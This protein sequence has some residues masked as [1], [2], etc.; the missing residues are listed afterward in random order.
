VKNHLAH[1]QTLTDRTIRRLAKR[2]E[3][4]TIAELLVV[5]TADQF[6]RPP[7][8]QEIS[9]NVLTLQNRAAELQVQ[10]CAPVPILLGRH[11]IEMGMKPGPDFGVILDAA[12]DA[13]LEGQF[14]DFPQALRWLAGEEGLPVP[15]AV[16]ATL[17]SG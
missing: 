9:E 5:I 17:P 16:R 11:L 10:V 3:P 14:F 2:L 12:Y 7:R 8:A 13:Q 15:A 4:A 6:G 1:L